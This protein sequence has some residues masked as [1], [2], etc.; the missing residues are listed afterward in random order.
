MYWA[1]VSWKKKQNHSDG[2]NARCPVSPTQRTT[3]RG[4][5]ARGS[6]AR[7]LGNDVCT[8]AGAHQPPNWCWVGHLFSK[9]E[10]CR[11]QKHRQSVL[12]ERPSKAS[13]KRRLVVP[14]AQWEG[15]SPVCSSLLMSQDPKQF[16]GGRGP[17]RHSG[18]CEGPKG[19]VNP[20]SFSTLC[21]SRAWPQKWVVTGSAH[22]SPNFLA[23]GPKGE[24]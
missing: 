19:T 16:F 9:P 7:A 15:G 22:Q 10:P 2:T 20:S 8:K 24:A 17:G 12:Q 11:E 5:N 6:H 1:H 21:S 18:R 13:S 23:G 14:N 3:Q 4:Q